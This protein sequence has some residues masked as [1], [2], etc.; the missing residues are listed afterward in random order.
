LQFDLDG[1]AEGACGRPVI[2]EYFDDYSS[3]AG[4]IGEVKRIGFWQTIKIS[5]D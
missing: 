3:F 4:S 5:D 2:G 1:I